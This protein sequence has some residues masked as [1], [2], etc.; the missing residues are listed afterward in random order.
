VARGAGNVWL[1]TWSFVAGVNGAWMPATVGYF[2][3]SFGLAG[4]L[5]FCI[6]TALQPLVC[7][8][9]SKA[10]YKQLK[11]TN[12]LTESIGARYGHALEAFTV[13]VML[14]VLTVF[15]AGEL[16]AVADI[17]ESVM[18]IDRRVVFAT[19]ALFS[20]YST[21]IGGALV[22]LIM[23]QFNNMIAVVAAVVLLGF[24]LA[25]AKDY[26]PPSQQAL[27]W[28]SSTEATLL[29]FPGMA[30][31]NLTLAAFCEVFWQK[32]IWCRRKSELWP[33]ACYAGVII[34]ALGCL[35]GMAAVVAAWKDAAEGTFYYGDTM[36]PFILYLDRCGQYD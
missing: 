24:L 16:V 33:A 14:L 28:G 9:L 3:Y 30:W 36:L 34:T 27:Q 13:A 32:H 17:F 10:A 20:V 11:E 15:L 1:I 31:S 22:G 4:M 8:V 6:A 7:G 21:F 26:R 18:V 2:S 29:A 23:S 19:A 35:W 5:C 12:S 25:S